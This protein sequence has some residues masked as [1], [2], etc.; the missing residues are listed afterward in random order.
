MSLY[1][2]QLTNT[3]NGRKTVHLITAPSPE[4]ARAS[5]YDS[6]NDD[7]NCW[8]VDAPWFLAVCTTPVDTELGDIRPHRL[9]TFNQHQAREH[10]L[11][12]ARMMEQQGGGFASAIAT[13]FFRADNHNSAQLLAAFPALFRQYSEMASFDRKLG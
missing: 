13:A 6:Y 10:F 8:E 7:E 2:V 11:P 3:C 12:A 4:T 1:Y 9:D 5:V